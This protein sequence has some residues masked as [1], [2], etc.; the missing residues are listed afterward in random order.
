[1]VREKKKFWTNFHIKL[2]IMKVINLL[3]PILL[4]GNLFN[5]PNSG[6]SYKPV[7]EAQVIV[8]PKSLSVN[9]CCRFCYAS[10]GLLGVASCCEAYLTCRNEA[11]TIVNNTCQTVYYTCADNCA[12]LN[13]VSCSAGFAKVCSRE[14]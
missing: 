1:L 9:D 11:E 2:Y 4:M 8:C 6:V 3:V 14:L 12:G 13:G 7:A 5:T 10:T